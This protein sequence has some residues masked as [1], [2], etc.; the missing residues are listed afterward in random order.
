MRREVSF[1]FFKSFTVDLKENV[2]EEEF[3]S[4]LERYVAKL[5]ET[6]DAEVSTLT[7]SH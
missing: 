7:A 2:T 5:V 6:A 4:L 1:E 3:T